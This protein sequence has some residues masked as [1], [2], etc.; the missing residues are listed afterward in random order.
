[1][2]SVHHDAYGSDKQIHS[3]VGCARYEALGKHERCVCVSLWED[4]GF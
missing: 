1:M 2:A 4:V 3:P